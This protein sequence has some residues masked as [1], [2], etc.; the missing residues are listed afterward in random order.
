L[1]AMMETLS[2]SGSSVCSF[3]LGKLTSKQPG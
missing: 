2:G 1:D 3:F